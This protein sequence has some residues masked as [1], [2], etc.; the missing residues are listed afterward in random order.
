[1]RIDKWVGVML[2]VGVFLAGA[3]LG[4]A[5]DDDPATDP[6]HTAA[7]GDEVFELRTYTAKPGKLPGVLEELEFAATLFERHGMEN[8]GYWVPT[9]EPLSN[10]TL[11]YILKYP[12]RQAAES[13]WD[14]FRNDPEW[15]QAFEEFNRDGRLVAGVN[16]I[17]VRATDFSPIQ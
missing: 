1:M 3:G 13:S 2:L 4:R 17:F 6:A 11:I 15:R 5:T 7:S 9:E 14:T 10:N 16:S 12:S 8:I